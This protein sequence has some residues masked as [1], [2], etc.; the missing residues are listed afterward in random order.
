MV[1]SLFQCPQPRFLCP[2]LLPQI[3]TTLNIILMHKLWQ[4]LCGCGCVPQILSLFEMAALRKKARLGKDGGYGQQVDCI[5][6]EMEL[7][8]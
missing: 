8:R 3:T 1:G 4:S 6:A 7:L 2:A 5:L